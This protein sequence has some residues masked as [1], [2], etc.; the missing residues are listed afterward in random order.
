MRGSLL[1]AIQSLYSQSKSC[2][3]VLRS[4]SDLFLMGVGLRQG[5]ALSPILFVIYMDRISR[6]RSGVEGL[7]VSD[8]KIASLLFADHVVLM[9]PSAL[10][11]QGSLDRFAAECEAA[12]MRISTSKSEAMVLRRKPVDCLL[13]VGNET[14]S[15]VKEFKYIRLLFMSKGMMGCELDRRVRAVDAVLNALHRT[16]VTKRELSWK[17]KLLIYQSSVVPTLTYGH[18]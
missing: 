7:Q 16:V 5:C 8:L 1:R 9:A 3:R 14:L 10:D 2:V 11:L 13:Q 4:K 6:R 18:E 17:T 15:Q 12:G